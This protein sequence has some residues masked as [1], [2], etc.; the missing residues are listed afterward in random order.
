MD[1]KKV[2]L[3]ILKELAKGNKNISKEAFGISGEE[4]LSIC[5]FL[6]EERLINDFDFYMDSSFNFEKT[7]V[8]LNGD[9]YLS[10][11]STFMKTYK[12]LKEFRGWIPGY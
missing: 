10:D 3:A 2:R 6:K 5:E 4:L 9:K 8:T 1:A 7:N 12:G 11:N